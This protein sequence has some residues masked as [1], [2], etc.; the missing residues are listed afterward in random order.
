MDRTR[1]EHKNK[2]GTQTALKKRRR[3]QALWKRA[4]FLLSKPADWSNQISEK[5]H[6]KHYVD[7]I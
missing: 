5:K 2:T 3:D 1:Q 7:E 6:V 4:A